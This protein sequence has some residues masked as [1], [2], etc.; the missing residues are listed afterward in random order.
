MASIDVTGEAAGLVT[1]NIT[2]LTVLTVCSS[3]TDMTSDTV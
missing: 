2:V 1:I 3:R